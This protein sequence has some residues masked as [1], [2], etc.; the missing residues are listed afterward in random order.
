M[1]V[2]LIES[3]KRRHFSAFIR[4]VCSVNR[5][6]A[7]V[8]YA[9]EFYLG[10]WTMPVSYKLRILYRNV[11]EN[12]QGITETLAIRFLTSLPIAPRRELQHGVVAQI[13]DSVFEHSTFIVFLQG[14]KRCSTHEYDTESSNIT[15][16]PNKGKSPQNLQPTCRCLE[17]L[18]QFLSDTPK[19]QESHINENKAA[20]FFSF[21]YLEGKNL[22]RLENAIKTTV[23]CTVPLNFSLD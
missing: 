17:K 6:T 4:E 19:L 5:S 8:P 11:R 2:F 22:E 13:K 3:E 12:G 7:S 16:V 1:A 10:Q 20:P 14:K 23:K 21:R 9:K 15:A 18:R